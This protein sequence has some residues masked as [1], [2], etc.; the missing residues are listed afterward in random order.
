VPIRTLSSREFNQQAIGAKNAPKRG[1]VFIIERGKPAHVLL[2]HRSVS[3]PDRYR[4]VAAEAVED[5]SVAGAQVD[6]EIPRLDGFFR[7]PESL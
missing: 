3:A 4:R 1:P 6:F 2:K 7:T 5:R